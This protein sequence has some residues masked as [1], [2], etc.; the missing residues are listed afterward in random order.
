MQPFRIVSW[1]LRCAQNDIRESV[2][3]FPDYAVPVFLSTVLSLRS[4]AATLDTQPK[5]PLL[6]AMLSLSRLLLL[7]LGFASA[8]MAAPAPDSLFAYDKSAPLNVTEVQRE[9]RRDALVHDITFTPAGEPVSAYIVQPLDTRPEKS[10]AA[11][12]YVHWLGEAETTSRAEFLNEAVALAETGVTSV[13]VDAMWSAPDWYR[14]RV[15]EE[16]FDR[17]I[18]QVVEIR[19][20]MDLLLSLP[21][22]DPTRVAFVGHDFGAMYGMIAGALDRRARTYVFVA[23]T[24]HF[25]DWFLYAQKPKNLEAYKTQ[26]APIDPVNFIGR[27]APA[28]VLLQFAQTDE[29][30]TATAAAK[31]YAAAQPRKQMVTYA[32]GH[33][34]RTAEVARDRVGWLLRELAR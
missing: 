3:A 32:A 17:S 29:Y 7:G 14:S 13:L 26:L 19:R 15:P 11:I 5:S 21:E 25:I 4:I 33:D 24:P 28:P 10:C 20:A 1:I 6:S 8:L 23:P 27:L 18:R 22:V 16:D 30:V 2:A 9:T 12:L 31:F 34:L